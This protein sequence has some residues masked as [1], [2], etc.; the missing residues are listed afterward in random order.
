MYEPFVPN[1]AGPD[2]DPRQLANGYMPQGDAMPAGYGPF[3][4]Q[5]GGMPALGDITM[6]Q[7]E[8]FSGQ[9]QLPQQPRQA[10]YTP[11]R[12]YRMYQAYVDAKSEELR[13]QNLAARYY[14]SKQWSEENRRKIRRRGQPVLTS[15]RIKRKCDF[16]VGVEQ[17]LRRDVKAF[18][19]NPIQ[20]K[21]AWIASASLRYVQ[22]NNTWPDLASEAAHFAFVYG[23]AAVR[24]DIRL[25]RG[26]PEILKS[27]VK[28]DRFFYDPRSEAW[29]FE[30]ARYLGTH[31]WLDIDEA[32]ELLPAGRKMIEALA[33]TGGAV[34][35]S[36]VPA[37]WQKEKN[38]IDTERRRI[39]V[40]EIHYKCGQDWMFDYLCGPVSLLPHEADPLTGEQPYDFTSPYRDED[41][42]TMHPFCAWSAYVDEIGDRYGVV[43]D[44]FSPQDEINMRKSKLLHMLS[45][46]QTMG[47]KGA[48]TDQNEMKRQ[49]AMP[50]GHVD[51]NPGPDIKFEILNQQDQIAGQATLLE[52]AE[53]EIENL[54][55][56]PGLAGRG[57]ESQSG[58]AIL[59]QQNSGMTELSP[60][61]ER[62]RSWK[63][64]SFRKDW[65]MVRQFYTSSRWIRITGDAGAPQYIGLNQLQV[66][67]NGRLGMS[68][69]VP[70][71]DV[72]I[73]LDEG[74]DTITM[75]EEL[76]DSLSKLPPGT[77]PPSVLIMLSNVKDKEKILQM[78]DEANKPPEQLV[79]LQQLMGRLEALEKAANIDKTISET[80]KTR[81]GAIESAAKAGIMANAMPAAAQMFPLRYSQPGHLA[82]VVGSISAEQ[83]AGMMGDEEDESPENQM[84]KDGG[85]P[86]TVDQ[87]LPGDDPRLGAPGGL[88]MNGPGN[89]AVGAAE[90]TLPTQ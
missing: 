32:L 45:V 13:E 40:I 43:R 1:Q 41:N 49:L 80:E 67:G 88:P 77:V 7:A 89:S 24:N 60:L 52:K 55:V 19:R 26:K 68:N 83:Q 59:A 36:A 54:S 11:D 56:N 17:R 39:F 8:M 5:P 16:L 47:T 28:P 37:H 78:I 90:P 62:C 69:Y 31:Q 82:G 51:V 29:D 21:S 79:A 74:P 6:L 44:M 75:Q 76:L 71:L 35:L 33:S 50:D 53:N 22:D 25:K 73:L 20:E 87:T 65:C 12:L 10:P 64:K 70:E 38:W 61:F 72:D 2:I 15:N 4:A 57:V 58:R 63:L 34:P 81:M 48:I 27:L 85:E 3:M 18:G 9:S 30:D 86:V 66:Q 14:H 42:Q 84:A 23:V 46:R